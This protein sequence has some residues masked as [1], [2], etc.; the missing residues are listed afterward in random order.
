[1]F[2]HSQNFAGTAVP[3]P[4]LEQRKTTD[5]SSARKS[6]ADARKAARVTV[7][8]ASGPITINAD[9]SAAANIDGLLLTLPEGGNVSFRNAANGFQDASRE[10]LQAMRLAIAQEQQRL[11]QMKWQLVEQINAAGTPEELNAIDIGGWF[12]NQ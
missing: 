10:D 1:M 4:S 6:F 12:L 8:L 2:Q 11:Y 9:D 7:E 3:E 5:L